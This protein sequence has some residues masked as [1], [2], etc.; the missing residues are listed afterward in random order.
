MSKMWRLMD[1]LGLNITNNRYAILLTIGM[2][3]ENAGRLLQPS[4]AHG[5]NSCHG[6]GTMPWSPKT[7]NACALHLCNESQL[8]LSMALSTS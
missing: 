7:K 1:S 3:P 4:S 2:E 5:R 6:L 8:I